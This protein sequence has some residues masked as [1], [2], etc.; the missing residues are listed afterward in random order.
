M[1]N[2]LTTSDSPNLAVL[3]KRVTELETKEAHLQ[4]LYNQARLGYQLLDENGCL[5]EVN[6]IWLDSLGYREEEVLGRNFE[7]FLHPYW[8]DHFKENFSRFKAVGE[9]L[10]IDFEMV[11]KDASN[12]SVTFHGR[13][14]RDAEGRFQQIHCIFQDITSQRRA[15]E[16]REAEHE[17]LRICHTSTSISDLMQNLVGF[18]Q[19]LT[20]CE[21]VGVRLHQGEDFPYYETRGFPENFVRAENSLCS[22]DPQGNL[23]RDSKGNPVL[24]CMCGNIICGRFD[25]AK[26]FFSPFGSFWSNCTTELLATTSD[27][28]RQAR[29][30]NR[31]N[32]EGYESVALI[33]LRNQD[34]TFGLFQFNDHRR[35]RFSPDRIKQ[36]EQLAAYV[37][38]TLAKYL[39]DEELR[40][41]EMKYRLIVENA[42][43]A[44]IINRN[45]AVLLVNPTAVRLFGYSAEQLTAN[46]LSEFIHHDDRELVINFHLRRLQGEDPHSEHSFRII[47]QDSAVKW[48]EQNSSLI[49]WNGKPACLN[50]LTDIT[51]RRQ[52][53]LIVQETDAILQAILNA[54]PEPIFLINTKGIILAANKA[55]TRRLKTPSESLIGSDLYSYLS[56]ELTTTRRQ[57]IEL[58]ISSRQPQT[59]QDERDGM[60]IEHF[61]YPV[62]GEN[63]LVS[64]VAIFAM[65]IT[66]RTQAEKALRN[67]EE[68]YHTL[69]ESSLD[70]ILLTTPDGE[71]LDINPATC[72]MFGGTVDEIRQLGRSG[73][74]DTA[75]PRLAAALEI[76]KRTGM[77]S[78][79]LTCIRKNGIRFPSEVSTSVFTDKTGNSRTSMIIRDITERKQAEETLRASLAEK[80]VL[81]RE[82]HHRIKNNMT[83]IIGL[84]ELQRL[85]MAD[86]QART[87]LA[88]LSSRVRA[89]SLV[90]EKLYRSENLANIDFQDYLQS[91]VSHLRTSFGS[92][93]ICCEIAAQ[94]VEMPLDLAVPCGM[95]INELVTNA[96]KYAFPQARSDQTDEVD[97]IRIFFSHVDD[98]FTLSVA[99]NGVGLLSGF[100]FGT[101]K[102]LGLVLVRMLGQHQLGGKYEID[103]TGGT[104]FTLTF[105]LRNGRNS[106]D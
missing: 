80:E 45:E 40:Q 24:E 37:S 25:P 103:Q 4:Q 75:D 67:S 60:T 83:A 44:I 30:R 70:A 86:P 9:V 64:H 6:Q 96:L 7:D 65:D 88:E 17:L 104:R 58:V 27:T 49:E 68:R 106:H 26:P 29:T 48:V 10:D 2:D 35:N 13:I 90:H 1:M 82:V 61:L 99:D 46:S 19:T 38:L 89:M 36:L 5:I 28:D 92:P 32:G 63:G 100:D 55:L 22:W 51:A 97:R 52:A 20:R 85:V 12:L 41:S 101:T 59:F 31:C 16:Q 95:I 34:T 74:M 62:E 21:A 8:R 57:K 69:F 71:I 78:G 94:G 54:S 93:G 73:I 98:T 91:L 47:C 50:F 76:R 43:E 77:F 56:P 33:P 14:N 66:E 84:F 102:S 105:S 39:K 23:F 18:L 81:L 3:Q 87:I 15:E 53:E 42:Q 79:E 11:K 72:R